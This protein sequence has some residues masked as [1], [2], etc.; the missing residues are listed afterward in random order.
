MPGTNGT[1]EED[2]SSVLMASTKCV[3]ECEETAVE[4]AVGA[5]TADDTA[6]DVVVAAAAAAAAKEFCQYGG[7]FASRLAGL[8]S[9]RYPGKYPFHHGDSMSGF[10]C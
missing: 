7:G 5:M 3:S 10:V 2:T 6:M 9:P 8:A 4:M 1:G